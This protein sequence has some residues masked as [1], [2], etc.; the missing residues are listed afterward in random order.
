MGFSGDLL[1]QAHRGSALWVAAVARAVKCRAHS[2]PAIPEGQRGTAIDE[3]AHHLHTTAP[4][5]LTQRVIVA[6]RVAVDPCARVEQPPHRLRMSALNGKDQHLV[7]QL[8]RYLS[9]DHAGSTALA[10]Q[11]GNLRFAPEL[12]DL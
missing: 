6:L 12:R 3:L 1:D 4:A 2:A 11:R 8:R 5:C 10:Q 7:T 9:C